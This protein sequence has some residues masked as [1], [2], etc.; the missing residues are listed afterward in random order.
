MLQAVRIGSGI[1]GLGLPSVGSQQEKE[2]GGGFSKVTDGGDSGGCP[3]R[4]SVWAP[5]GHHVGTW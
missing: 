5:R 3:R 4:G 2:A 1:T